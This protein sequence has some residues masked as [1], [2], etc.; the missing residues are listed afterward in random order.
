MPTRNKFVPSGVIPACLLPFD[1]DF[2]IALL[3]GAAGITSCSQAV[4]LF[5]SLGIDCTLDLGL[6]DP[7]L[8][9]YSLD[10]FCGCSCPDS[11][12]SDLRFST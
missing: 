8:A 9:G 11:V 12:D 5:S 3:G 4:D 1:D 10:M 6:F 2:S 7:T